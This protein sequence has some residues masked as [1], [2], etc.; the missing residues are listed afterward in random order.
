MDYLHCYCRGYH[1]YKFV[2]LIIEVP[3]KSYLGNITITVRAHIIKS[4]EPSIIQGINY[5][6]NNTLNSIMHRLDTLYIL[7]KEKLNGSTK[8]EISNF[9]T[10]KL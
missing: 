1:V 2:S 10:F 8:H 6:Y 9:S 4:E 5:Y 7:Q 3:N